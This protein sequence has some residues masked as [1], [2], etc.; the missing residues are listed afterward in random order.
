MMRGIK[1]GFGVTGSFCTA[2]GVLPHIEKLVDLGAEVHPIISR[3]VAEFDTRFTTA[4][5]FKAR[6]REI[7]GREIIET[8]TQAEP[9]GPLKLMDVIVVA[10]CTGNTTAK[11]A[12]AI[13]D[14]PVT[15][16][17]K[18]QLRNER[19]VVLG[20]ASNDGLGLGARNIGCLLNARNIYFIPFFQDDPFNKGRSLMFRG[21]AI[22][23]TILEAL[24]GKQLQPVLG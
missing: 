17:V 1:I 19:P 11:I 10:P 18:A 9:I 21:E 24:K 5:E 13:T 6:L 22:A 15:M 20:V 4:K 7:T 16:A 14:T 12:N 2:L 23:D 3:N 8:I